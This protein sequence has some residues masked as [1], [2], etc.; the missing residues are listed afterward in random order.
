MESSNKFICS[1]QIIT[2]LRL[3]DMSSQNKGKIKTISGLQKQ[4]IH[5][6]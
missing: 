2:N 1:V 3:K 5:C 4:R 6:Q